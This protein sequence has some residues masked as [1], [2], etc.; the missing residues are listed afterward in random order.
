VVWFRETMS[1]ICDVGMPRA[2]PAPLRRGVYWWS[3]EIAELRSTCV[4]RQ[5][6]RC[7]RRRRGNATM[8]ATLY[9]A[10][11]DAKRSLKRAIAEAKA[12]T[13]EEL[14]KTLERDP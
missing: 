9:E 3:Q 2:R 5:Y 10:Y 12:R 7:R 14:L 6:T 1:L 11:R 4:I 8:E 13:W